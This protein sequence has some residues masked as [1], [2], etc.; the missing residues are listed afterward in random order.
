MGNDIR[1]MLV[2]TTLAVLS[3]CPR[4]MRCNAGNPKFHPLCPPEIPTSVR[5]TE[6]LPMLQ[7]DLSGPQH[8][9]R[10]GDA[11]YRAP[12]RALWAQIKPLLGSYGKSGFKGSGDP[13]LTNISEAANAISSARIF[14][15]IFH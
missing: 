6:T 9:P 14:F 11:S 12:K 15:A 1:P 13:F 4:M 7:Q 10:M 5:G 3:S 2:P 8:V